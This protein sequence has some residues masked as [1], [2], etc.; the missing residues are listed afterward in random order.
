MIHAEYQE[1]ARQYAFGRCLKTDC[2]NE[3]ETDQPI[4]D[5]LPGVVC[6][7]LDPGRVEKARAKFPEIDFR[8]GSIEALPFAAHSLDRVFDFS[9]IDHL[10]DYR[11][12]LD[13]YRRVLT[14][15]G[16]LVL[17]VW[18]TEGPRAILWPTEWG[19]RQYFFPQSEF[20]AEVCSRFAIERVTEFAGERFGS[21]HLRL[22]ICRG[23][24]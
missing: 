23:N 16:R 9:T 7:E 18:V 24:I 12:A 3:A 13:E 20:H 10:A 14:P 6:L 22:Y 21:A 8:Q 19:G 2:W 1:I 17:V 15:G 11:P 5:L 4:A